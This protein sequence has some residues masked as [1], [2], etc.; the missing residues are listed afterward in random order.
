TA[1]LIAQYDSTWGD[2]QSQVTNGMSTRTLEG[3]MG[4]V[5]N[6]IVQDVS[7][8]NRSNTQFPFLRNFDVYQ[9][10]SWVD[11]AANN[12]VGNNQESSSEAINYASGLIM[13]G[14]ATGNTA[15]RDLGIYLYTTEVD[16]VNTYYFNVKGTNA[17]PKQYTTDQGNTVRTLVTFLL[18]NGGAYEG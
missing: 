1:A 12:L 3:K 10:H 15:L 14:E 7:N 13:W 9:D 4:D 17:F 16:A 11:G 5:V 6:Q 18:G 8:Y 2:S